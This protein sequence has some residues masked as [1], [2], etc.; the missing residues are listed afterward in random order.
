MTVGLRGSGIY[1][2]EQA[3]PAPAIH[4]GH[5]L[6]FV[7]REHR[8]RFASDA[9]LYAWYPPSRPSDSR[10]R[11]TTDIHRDRPNVAYRRLADIPNRGAGSR[12]WGKA[13]TRLPQGSQTAWRSLFR[14]P[15]LAQAFVA[16]RKVVGN[17]LS[18]PF[19]GEARIEAKGFGD[20]R[21]RLVHSAQ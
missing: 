11:S 19:D 9:N 3:P 7:H 4:G 12:V 15:H 10:S 21:F 17:V 6:A 5:R 13:I 14:K 1:W 8:R 18:I 20:E 2:T 16:G